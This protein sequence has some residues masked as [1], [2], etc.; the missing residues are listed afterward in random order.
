MS[1][2]RIMIGERLNHLIEINNMDISK[3]SL[4]DKG[5]NRSSLQKYL[6]NVRRPNLEDIINL[7]NIFN[8]TVDYLVGESEY[9]LD[10]WDPEYLD[11]FFTFASEE[12]KRHFLQRHRLNL[13]NNDSTYNLLFA[14]SHFLISK[15]KSFED[16]SSGESKYQKELIDHVIA[17]VYGIIRM[18]NQEN[19]HINEL[20][21]LLGGISDYIDGE[22][23]FKDTAIINSLEKQTDKTDEEKIEILKS[24]IHVNMTNGQKAL[25]LLQELSEKK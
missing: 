11:E 4:L 21:G 12:V 3:D 20:K 19:F 6:T 8:T 25:G 18:I 1:D 22:Y 10:T 9:V 13:P 7:A 17:I 23:S 24:Y 16:F 14:L 15:D 5:F 2:E